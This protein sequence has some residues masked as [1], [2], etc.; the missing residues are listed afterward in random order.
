MMI[1]TILLSTSAALTAG[2]AMAP[3]A[4]H[5][6]APDA[7]AATAAATPVLSLDQRTMLRCSAAFA[8]VARQQA[9]GK[10]E[11]K[12][13]PPMDPRG[14]EFFIRASGQVIEETNMTHEQIAAALRTEAQGLAAAGRL[15]AVMPACLLSLD[16]SGL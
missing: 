1:R 6:Q 5:A 7:R 15:D 12:R 10:A 16:A 4:S 11:A 14:K 13:Y 3:A 9:E 2:A 8:I